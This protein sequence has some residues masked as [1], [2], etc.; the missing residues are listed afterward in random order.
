MSISSDGCQATIPPFLGRPGLYLEGSVSPALSDVDIRIV[1]AGESINAPLLKGE[2]ALET[3]T[4][5]DGS[6]IG[7]PLYDDTSYHVEASKVCAIFK[8]KLLIS[9]CLIYWMSP[10]SIMVA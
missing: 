1:A 3:K 10:N 7:G 9:G 5:A 2:L 8:H 6:F 4:G